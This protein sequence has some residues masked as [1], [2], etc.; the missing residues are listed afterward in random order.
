MK[1]FRK[2][3]G[4][5]VPLDIHTKDI[6]SKNP[7]CSVHIG[8]DSQNNKKNTIFCTVVAYKFGNRGVH[9]V[10]VL[11]REP[12]IRDIWTRLY[13]EAEYSIMVAQWLDQHVNIKINIDMD[14]NEDITKKSN[15]VI[16]ATRGWASSLGYNVSTKPEEL[17]ATK[18]ADYHCRI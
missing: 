9:Y 8:T 2:I 10:F 17:I 6:L 14:Y 12:R 1:Y 3:D 18:A 4:N 5:T 11:K 7:D 13:K 15:N 16:A